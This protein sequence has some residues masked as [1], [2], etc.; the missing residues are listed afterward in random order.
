MSKTFLTS[1]PHWGHKGV[2][3]F[4]RQDGSPLRPWDDPDEMDEAMVDNWNKVV[5]PED[6]VYVL[7]D[8]AINRKAIPTIARC[9]GRKKLVKGNHDIFKLKDYEPYFD[10]IL[11]YHVLDK[12]LLCHIPV[13]PNQIAR[14]CEGNIHGHLHSN[15]VLK[16]DGTPDE[17]YIN[18]SVEHTNFTP[19]DFEEIKNGWRPY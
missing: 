17:R 11:A 1:D 19:I 13:H 14:W 15:L 7:G 16:E 5:N 6:R 10:D 2:T 8:L 3:H 4:T 18:V 12:F 9:N